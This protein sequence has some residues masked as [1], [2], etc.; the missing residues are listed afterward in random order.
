MPSAIRRFFHIPE[1]DPEAERAADAEPGPSWREYFYRTFLKVWIPTGF[2]VVDAIVAASFFQPFQPLAMGVS[3]L[4][5][6][7]VEFLLYEYL[8]YRPDSELSRS[9]RLV[10]HRTPFRPFPHGRWTPEGERL[11]RGL[12][13]YEDT[14]A[15]RDTI[16]ARE[17]R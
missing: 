9:G 7:Y 4:V 2:L 17:F 5:A 11:R 15:E 14:L 16:D 8:W 1:P 12:P 10:F 6:V 13:A 3:L